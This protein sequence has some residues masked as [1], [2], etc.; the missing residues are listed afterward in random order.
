MRIISVAGKKDSGKTSLSS[1]IIKELTN[2]DYKVA[3]IKHSHHKMEMD[4]EGTDTY[5]H[6]MAGSRFTVGIGNRTY[7][8]INESFSLERLLFLIKLIDEPDFVV[9]EG[10]KNYNYPKFST[11]PD[12]DDEYTIEVVDAKNLSDDDLNL[13]VDKAEKYAYDLLPTLY[14]KDCGY[15]DPNSIAKAIINDELTYDNNKQAEVSL[16]VDGNVIGL[17]EF[18]EAFIKNTIM[19]MLKSIKV[20]EY[21]ASDFNNIQISINKK[22]K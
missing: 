13:L 7:F 10:F 20:K 18:V 6:T 1:R 12:L 2:R 9:I 5:K 19:G 16:S 4:H 3:S 15:K 21:G 22:E 11:S 8:N 17:N 14:T